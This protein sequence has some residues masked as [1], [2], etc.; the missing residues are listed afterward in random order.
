MQHAPGA[1]GR[2]RI[3]GH[4]QN[5]LV[6]RLLQF[7][8]QVQ[9]FLGGPGVQVAGG[10]VGDN[11]RRVGDNRPRDA[12][13]LL[14]AAGKLARPM[15]HAIR[16]AN[17]LQDR[18]HLALAFGTRQRQEQERQL[19]ILI[20]A[21]DRQQVIE[22]EHEPDVPRAPARQL[23]LRH[24]GDEVLP[25]PDL[26]LAGAIQTGDQIQQ[27]GFA[28]AAWPH[29]AEIFAFRHVEVQVVEDVDLLAA[30]RE[31]LVNAPHA[32]NRLR[33]HTHSSDTSPKRKRGILANA[34]GWHR[35]RRSGSARSRPCSAGGTCPRRRRGA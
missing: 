18:H 29:Q 9:D 12:D 3:V 20:G 32:H 23:P 34:S 4:Q 6:Q 28:R 8:E 11:Q 22:L 13:A 5:R 26:A 14:L 25:D 30:A 33:G 15:S 7:V 16:Q 24:G 27:R 19:D 21:Q 10:L 17:Q 35:A 31:V 2:A 1:L